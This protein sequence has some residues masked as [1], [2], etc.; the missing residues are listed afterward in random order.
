MASKT[1]KNSF[2][3]ANIAHKKNI[4]EAQIAAQIAA[5]CAS[6]KQLTAEELQKWAKDSIIAIATVAS[7]VKQLQ[8][9]ANKG[10]EN[11]VLLE[12]TQQGQKDNNIN[13]LGNKESSDKNVELI[14]DLWGPIDWPIELQNTK[15][16]LNIDSIIYIYGFKTPQK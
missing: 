14:G 8:N 1:Q 12:N 6:L 7:F 10:A 9:T 11:A 5:D 15:G 4:K 3:A 2:T 13:D 16:Q